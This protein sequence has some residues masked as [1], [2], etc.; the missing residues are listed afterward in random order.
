MQFAITMNSSAAT[1]H[2]L[3]DIARRRQKAGSGNPI[4]MLQQRTT[5]L[6]YPD[7]E[8]VLKGTGW[9]TVGA[10]ATRLY[11]PERITNDLDIAV[12]RRDAMMVRKSFQHAEWRFA[13]ELSIGGCRWISPE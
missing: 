12:C 11:M 7:I 3:I 2:L 6:V 8:R 9:A 4:D 13:G 10:V 1:R 5:L